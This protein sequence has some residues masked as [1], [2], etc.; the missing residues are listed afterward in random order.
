MAS[1]PGPLT[2]QRPGHQ[3]SRQKWLQWKGLAAGEEAQCVPGSPGCRSGAKAALRPQLLHWLI[4]TPGTGKYTVTPAR[5]RL[6]TLGSCSAPSHFLLLVLALF[7]SL[8][9]SQTR[10][11]P[12]VLMT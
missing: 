11:R 10:D 12:W 2:L 7:L 9:G 3:L 1:L 6:L 5:S 4:P 8:A